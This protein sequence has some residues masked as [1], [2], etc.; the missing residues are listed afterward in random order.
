MTY[1]QKFVMKLNPEYEKHLEFTVCAVVQPNRWVSEHVRL[2]KPH[3]QT[4]QL[5]VWCVTQTVEIGP[6]NAL[7]F[8]LPR[9]IA[10]SACI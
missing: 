4:T 7:S 8:F 3:A 6:S 1:Q 5:W 9:F 2:K 10:F